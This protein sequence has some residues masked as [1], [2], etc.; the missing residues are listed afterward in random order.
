MKTGLRLQRKYRLLYAYFNLFRFWLR[1]KIIGFDVAN[2]L[3]QSVD[4][5]SLKVILNRYGATIGRYCDIDTG[6]IFH[7]CKDYSNLRIGNNCHIG[8][9]CFF[10]L[11]G[12]VT[13]ED[14]VV[15]SMQTTFITHQDMNKSGL[16]S[17]YPATSDDI[18]VEENVY[19]GTNAVILQGVTINKYAFV[20]AGAVVTKNVDQ[21]AL[22][23]GVPA[24]VIKDLKMVENASGDS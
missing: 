14:N 13:L 11:R 17:V 2:Q 3:I 6:L 22:V 23:G 15:V 16:S 8:K 10:D 5:I 1:K 24:K 19:I 9:D 12:K 20:A 7:N 4:K 18:V 21:Y